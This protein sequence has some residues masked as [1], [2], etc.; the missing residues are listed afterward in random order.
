MPNPD[1]FFSRALDRLKGSGLP[2]TE[3]I[4]F[5]AYAAEGGFKGLRAPNH[6]S[7]QHYRDLAPELRK[8]GVM[9]FRVGGEGRETSFRLVQARG[10]LEEAFFLSDAACFDASRPERH[11]T[12]PEILEPFRLMKGLEESGALNLA[13]ASGLL[14]RALDL[15]DGFPRVAPSRSASTFTFD[16]RPQAPDDEAFHHQNG[17]VEIDAVF[18]ARRKGRLKLVVAEAKHGPPGPGLAK[19]K[20]AYPFY[21]L[22]TRSLP[23]GAE[24]LP[25]YVRSWQKDARIHFGIC[26]CGFQDPVAH[27]LASFAPEGRGGTFFID[28]ES[29]PHEG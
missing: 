21:A 18:L 24:I 28:L 10:S 6:I 2:W 5:Q 25:V 13:L 3:P 23:E 8:A 4:P 7:V 1:G 22:L 27:C 11:W 19:H 17:Q 9:V 12:S 29:R 14:G 16:F 20:L 15:D 26:E